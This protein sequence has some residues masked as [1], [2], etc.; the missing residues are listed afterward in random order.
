[1]ASSITNGSR[2]DDRRQSSEVSA[3]G[4][5]DYYND[6]VL[7]GIDNNERFY[8][9][10][11]VKP[12]VDAVQ[13][14]Q[15]QTGNFSA[16]IGRAGGASVEIITKSGGNQ[17]HADAFEFFRND[18]LNA[19]GAYFSP[20]GPIPEWRQN[21]FGGSASGPILRDKTF[22]FASVEELR[23]V[24]GTPSPLQIVPTAADRAVVASLT[25]PDPI[26]VH[27]FNMYPQP[28]Q[29]T[30]GY[31]SAFN[32][33]QFVT[34]VDARVD[35]RI[36]SKDQL[37]GRFN[38]NPTTSFF[39]SYFP[40]CKSGS[41][42]GDTV[43]DGLYP[44]GEGTT[45][46]GV[47]P[48]TN[49]TKTYGAQLNYTHEFTSNLLLELRTGFFR[50][51][52]DSEPINVGTNAGT[53]LGIPNSNIPSDPHATGMPTIYMNDGS[54]NLGD[55]AAFPILNIGNSFQWNGDVIYTHG[56]H[57][58]KAGAALIRRQLNY[59]QELRP[60]GQFLFNKATVNGT[61]Y[62]A[63]V[64]MAMG[65]LP[66][67]DTRQNMFQ[68]EYFRSWEPSV[69][70]QDDWRLRQW[71]TLNL[72]VRYDVFTPLAEAK[73]RIA[74][75]DLNTLSMILGGTGGVK[76]DY[77]DFAPRLG[78]AAQIPHGMV[79]HGGYGIVYFPG[80]FG[81]SVTLFNLPYNVAFTCSPSSG[82]C[83]EGSGSLDQGPPNPTTYLDVSNLKNPAYSQSLGIVAKQTDRRSSYLQQFN[84]TL[85]KQL[86][87][88][89]FTI[90]YVGS[91]GRR[92]YGQAGWYMN[93]PQPDA[94]GNIALVNGSVPRYY[95]TQLPGVGNINYFANEGTSNYNAMQLIFERRITSGFRVSGNYTWSHGLNNFS[96]FQSN[97]APSTWR[98]NWKY[99]Y[100]N[101]DYEVKE[102]LAYTATYEIPFG[103]NLKGAEGI[104]LKGWSLSSS[105]YWQTG[106][107]FT[108][109]TGAK[110]P[111]AFND[112]NHGLRVNV[113]S[114]QS[115]YATG[116]PLS[117]WLNK[118]AFTA[119]VLTATTFTLGNEHS[120]QLYAPNIRQFDLA[121]FKTVPVE[122]LNVQFRA[123]CFNISNTPNFSSPVYTINSSNFGAITSTLIGSN[124]RVFQF[125][126][127]VQY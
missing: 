69:F 44:G 56:T 85:Q 32:Q 122:K 81:T 95:A 64:A 39:P 117:G 93:F 8:G 15:V 37:F 46:A 104:A 21:Q 88:N 78:F 108:V 55:Q 99:D 36:S 65:I 84:L 7:D 30:N 98:Y 42:N 92:Q 118:N 5:A 120:N 70:A 47:F 123:E 16:D 82:T 109:S 111:G 10:G 18:I 22:F 50:I 57:N 66:T 25:N 97:G 72:G 43:V 62:S 116:R 19:N 89:A 114:G 71:L 90:G 35:Q 54:G 87:N 106:L 63:P 107:P 127:K 61:T 124:P 67:T 126:L 112:E 29:G 86:G 48:G 13:E 125:A 110:P 121:A 34:T 53:K 91:L 73:D 76:T 6:N 45:G 101:S 3:N 100:G 103:N 68:M 83:P 24:Q 9:L 80:D 119:P 75:F 26:G 77:S 31:A 2:P 58:I 38:Y 51:N 20:G 28:N 11:G 49:T 14:I 1:M 96:G 102:R 52:I 79:L 59:L 105:G 4:Q 74:N 33:T 17:F 23:L 12:S 27:L 94:S 40:Q 113:V 115:F 41:C 60:E